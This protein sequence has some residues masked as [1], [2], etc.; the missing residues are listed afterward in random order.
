MLLEVIIAAL[1]IGIAAGGSLRR[2]NDLQ[3][4]GSSLIFAALM[5]QLLLPKIGDFQPSLAS[6]LLTGSF[7]VLLIALL[8]NKIT[9]PIILMSLGVLL[10]L[11]VITANSGMPVLAKVLPVAADDRIHIPM[12]QTTRFPWLADIIPWT[13]P[14]TLHGLVSA[15]DLFLSAGV[16]VLILS[17]MMYKGKRRPGRGGK[18]Q[19]G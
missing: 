14:G 8:T 15:G 11:I 9:P 7:A 19:Y 10:N 17:G 1:I 18:E 12:T 3:L 2:L 6:Y 4:R 5:I 13:L 16:F